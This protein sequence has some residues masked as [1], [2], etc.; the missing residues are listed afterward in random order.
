MQKFNDDNDLIDVPDD[1]SQD[2]VNTPR[3]KL[4]EEDNYAIA[5]RRTYNPGLD[6]TR[7]KQLERKELIIESPALRKALEEVISRMYRGLSFDMGINVVIQRPYA[8][9]YHS[10]KALKK[11]AKNG[12]SDPSIRSG[13]SDSSPKVIL[14]G[15]YMDYVG[16]MFHRLDIPLTIEH[17]EGSKPITNLPVYSIECHKDDMGIRQYEVNIL[18]TSTTQS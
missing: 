6:N 15:Y 17:F 3:K 12:T 18:N 16:K 9:I 4:P 11:C 13:G 1:E 8:C 2:A 10:R 14:W 7:I 5:W